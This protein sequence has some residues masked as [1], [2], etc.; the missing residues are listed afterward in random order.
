MTLPVATAAAAAL[1][2]TLAACGGP[3][4]PPP[5]TTAT[6]SLTGAPGMNGGLPAKV[7]VYWLR[8]PARFEGA[9]FFALFGDAQEALGPDLIAVDEHLLA[10]GETL[11]SV[12]TFDRPAETPAVVG[13]V[14]GFRDVGQP[15]WSATAPLTPNAA[16]PLAVTVSAAAVS[17]GD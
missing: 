14:A 7:K 8:A 4:P 1:T 2:L 17:F 15:G 6:L 10:P 12:R 9:D 16:N 11:G 5:P 13:V 3:P